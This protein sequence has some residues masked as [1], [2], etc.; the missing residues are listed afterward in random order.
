MEGEKIAVA[1]QTIILYAEAL[2]KM[3]HIEFEIAGFENKEFIPLKQYKDKWDLHQAV[4]ALKTAA[5]NFGG[6]TNDV[7]AVASAIKRIKHQ[8]RSGSSKMIFV[9]TDGQSGVGGQEKMRKLMDK[10]RDVRVF[11]WGV[12]SDMEEVVDT[13]KPYG[14]WIK[15]V[16]DLPV[17]VGKTL[18]N[19]LNRP[20]VVGKDGGIREFF[21][22]REAPHYMDIE[23]DFT[24]YLKIRDQFSVRGLSLGSASMVSFTYFILMHFLLMI[25]LTVTA[26]VTGSAT[27]SHIA[28]AACIPALYLTVFLLFEYMLCL[29]IRKIARKD[30]GELAWLDKVL[31]RA[32][33]RLL[34]KELQHS[35]ISSMCA[36]GKEG[37]VE[38]LFLVDGLAGRDTITSGKLRE[39]V[40]AEAMFWKSARQQLQPFEVFRPQV[41]RLARI[42]WE[43]GL[44]KEFFDLFNNGEDFFSETFVAHGRELLDARWNDIDRI[45]RELAAVSSDMCINFIKG[46][47]AVMFEPDPGT[48]ALYLGEVEASARVMEVVS[49]AQAEAVTGIDSLARICCRVGLPIGERPG[50]WASVYV[51]TFVPDAAAMPAFVALFSRM[52]ADGWAGFGLSQKEAVV[53]DISAQYRLDENQQRDLVAMIAVPELFDGGYAGGGPNPCL[54]ALFKHPDAEIVAAA[55]ID[56]GGSTY[57][58]ISQELNLDEAFV[59]IHY[60]EFAELL[61]DQLDEAM[62]KRIEARSEDLALEI[63]DTCPPR[64]VKLPAVGLGSSTAMTNR[65]PLTATRFACSALLLL[66]LI[67]LTGGA[68]VLA[69]SAM[70]VPQ[71]REVLVAHDYEKAPQA[72]SVLVAA[73]DSDSEPFIKSYISGLSESETL[74]DQAVEALVAIVGDSSHQAG[75]AAASAGGYEQWNKTMHDAAQPYSD[76]LDA[77][78]RILPISAERSTAVLYEVTSW[79]DLPDDQARDLSAHL[80]SDQSETFGRHCL[81]CLMILPAIRKRKNSPLGS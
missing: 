69:D 49:I 40:R 7:G 51:Q 21:F 4:L 48:F 52:H 3:K 44:W 20:V 62:W 59:A 34:N 66:C 32:S 73:H 78:Y 31:G 35:V 68:A 1:L 58:L 42:G 67:G 76:R 79:Q 77:A 38:G 19:E 64:L 74:T 14:R 70:T 63:L 24:L 50:L 60:G 75:Y 41:L 12:G 81:R 6:G 17:E 33:M 26:A 23:N 2:S 36:A 71:A 39:M 28:V 61:P 9:I 80:L 29:N 15:D 57:A 65:Y 53:S 37:T 8:A 25:G 22:G 54:K 30:Y 10:N 43:T 47:P 18:R 11:G 72:L 27:V 5:A 16:R 45:A 56:G 46:L 13:Y 55:V